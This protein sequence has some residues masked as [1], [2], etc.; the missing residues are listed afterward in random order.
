MPLRQIDIDNAV[1]AQEAAA[2]DGS[3]AIR[4]V[5]GPGTG[6]SATIEER[7]RWLLAQGTEPERIFA[8]SFTRASA[9]ELRDRIRLYC[10]RA[11]LAGVEAVSITTL[12]SLALRVLRRA[13][14]LAAYPSPAGPMVLDDWELRQVFETEFA[15]ATSRTPTRSRDIRIEHEAFWSTGQWAPGNFIPPDPPISHAERTSFTAF[16]RPRTQTYSCVL[17]GEIVRVAVDQIAVGALDVRDLLDLDELIVDEFQDLNPADLEFIDHLVREGAR[18]FVA[19][20]DDQSIY[21]FRFAD[22]T[23]IQDL[24]AQHG[25]AAH[26]LEGCFRCTP[27]VLE[28]AAR[29]I[30]RNPLPARI[31]KHLRS[32]Y[33]TAEPPLRGEAL[34]WRFQT[35]RVEAEA[36]ATSCQ[37]LIAAGVAPEQ[38]LILISDRRALVGHITNALQA[39]G[40]RHS[41][42]DTDSAKTLMKAGR[43]S[44][45]SE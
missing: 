18:T 31:P 25:A 20:D 10:T 14:L 17:P 3:A 7:V 26:E 4:L 13:G 28:G 32:L 27:S 2:R 8:V 24:V 22:P 30:E 38:I 6:K 42:P 39:S 37:R 23:G 9:T 29:L 43:R 11:G 36:I 35:H 34:V 5:A 41:P 16:H 19:G 45:S 21:S 44:P 12:H 1:A 15:N 33:A 40:V